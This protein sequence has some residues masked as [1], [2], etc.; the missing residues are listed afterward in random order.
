MKRRDYG[1]SGAPRIGAGTGA[2]PAR[3]RRQAF[4]AR[5][6]AIGALT[7]LA[8]CGA[9]ETTAP[10]QDSGRLTAFPGAEGYGRYAKGGRGGE[11]MFVTTLEDG[12]LGSLRACIEAE[13]PRVCIFRVGGVIRFTGERPPIINNPYITIAGQTA[14]G[15]GVL[16]THSGGE[17][18]FTP[19]VIKNTHNVVVRHVR[20]RPDRPSEQRGSN[21][22][23]TI[24]NS[25]NVILDHVSGSWA[26][27]ENVNGFGD[28]DNITISW[29][30]FAEGLVEHDKCALL[31][32]KPED[33]QNVSFIKNLCAHNGDRNPDANFMPGSCVEII[34]NVIY[35]AETEFVEVWEAY[36]GTPVSIVGNYFKGGPDTPPLTPAVKRLTLGS[37]GRSRIH[38]AD[39]HL[40]GADDAPLAAYSQN[41]KAVLVDQPTCPL[42]F[43]P[44]PALQ[45]YDEVLNSAG[46][47][48]RDL[49]DERVVSDVRLRTGAFVETPGVLP[50]M[51]GDAPATDIDNDGMSD[52]WERINGA[53]ELLFDPWEDA[54]RDGVPNL[55]E[56]LDYAH[57]QL[58]ANQ[59][60]A[61][62]EKA[63]G[64][65]R[66]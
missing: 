65:A 31:S 13:V 60:Q 4:A 49:V 22:A 47:M 6:L 27:D 11:I 46:A 34:N 3:R 41:V 52:A 24:E 10:P 18:G 39:N 16:L 42:T 53:D 63:A 5:A 25:A 64:A 54:D 2:A 57:R 23:F 1:L 32:T 45:A 35:H 61:L 12:G 9:D 51:N 36:G 26:A 15:D 28:N 21:D 8:A 58:L 17:T 33:P 43:E 37:E 40:D 20:V 50:P 38:L 66:N 44:M 7:A 48:P 30:V 55:E 56:Y 62:R 14:P 29:S 19:L 59:A